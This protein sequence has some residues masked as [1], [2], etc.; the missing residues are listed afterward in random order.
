MIIMDKFLSFFSG[1]HVS[2]SG[3]VLEGVCVCRG[4]G[5]GGGDLMKIVNLGVFY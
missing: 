2:G 1:R 5:G 4:G 3:G